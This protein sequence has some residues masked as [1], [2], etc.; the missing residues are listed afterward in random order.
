MGAGADPDMRIAHGW[1]TIGLLLLLSGV[2]RAAPPVEYPIG[3][4][5]LSL[6]VPGPGDT[7]HLPHRLISPRS[8]RVW[9]GERSYRLE[10][11]YALAP[12]EGDLLWLAA[13]P[14]ADS[15]LQ[16]E[17]R[18][19]P[20][21]LRG[22]WGDGTLTPHE[23]G[24]VIALPGDVRGSGPRRLP[25]GASLQVGGS[26]TFSLEFGNRQDV[27]LS[28]SLDLSIRGR[29][30][31]QVT[32]RAVLTDRNVPLQP[33]GT[34]ADLADLD[35]V[36][37]EVNSPWAT[38][39][40]GDLTVTEGGF[41]FLSHRREMEGL[42][43]RTGRRDAPR[44][45]G[46]IGRGV[47]RHETVA[48]FGQDGKQGPYP[49]FA[50]ADSLMQQSSWDDALMIAGSE[51]VWLDG[52]RLQR[53][54]DRDYTVDYSTGG[55]YFTVRRPIFARSEIRVDMQVRRG[56]FD[57]GYAWLSAGLGD[58]TRGFSVA[59]LREED[60][61]SSSATI[62]LGEQERQVL[63][64]AGDSSGAALEGGVHAVTPGEGR[65][66]LV[67][68]DTL[69]T[70]IFV[71]DV[72]A[73]G[74]RHGTYE[75]TFTLVGDEEGDYEID[76]VQSAVAGENVYVYVGRKLGM[77]LPGRPL[78]LPES[79]DV[80][81]LRGALDL[82][83]GLRLAG[84]GALSL[85]DQN[86]LSGRDDGDNA[87]GAVEASGRWRAAE[88]FGGRAD[89]IELHGRF[90]E[91]A[92]RFASAEPLEKAFYHREWNA[93]ANQ[94][95]GRGRQG[96]A[97]ITLRPGQ[98]FELLTEFES[99]RGSESFSAERWQGRIRR[100]GRI[101]ALAEG[102][103]GESES[104]ASPGR[105][106]RGSA[107]LGWQDAFEAEIGGDWEDLRRGE[108]G[109]ASGRC[110]QVLQARVSSGRLLPWVRGTLL[111]RTRRDDQI[112]ASRRQ[113]ASRT[114]LTQAEGEVSGERG[115]AHLRYARTLTEAADGRESRSD[116]AD[117]IGSYR[118]A[119]GVFS[120]EWRG[121]LTVEEAAL[122]E[123][124]LFYMGAGGGHYDSLGH[125]VGTGD[126][127]LYYARGD[128]SDL[129]TELE[130]ALRVAGR[131]FAALGEAW[132]RIEGS[133]YAKLQLGTPQ[134]VG[135]LL[136]DL[137]ALLTGAD[138]ARRYDALWRNEVT[139]KAPQGRPTPR[140]RVEQRRQTQRNISGFVRERRQDRI[141][142]DTR[143][144]VRPT[145]QTRLELSSEIER[146]GVRSGPRET[147]YD[148]REERRLALEG[149]WRFRAPLSV[150]VGGEVV[151][152]VFDPSAT[153][154][155][156]YVAELGAL[157]D[158]RR[159]G[160]VE[161]TLIRR[162]IEQNAAAGGAFLLDR[163]GWKLTIN[164]SLRLKGGFTWSLWVRVEEDEGERTITTGRMEARAFF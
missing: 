111:H 162:W 47:G 72:D 149:R 29:L 128:S 134:A 132:Q 121:R 67:E 16:V 66:S 163:P 69:A 43:L 22:H 97:G 59:W 138:P 49:L 110:A 147:S 137:G 86:I 54:E 53:G 34:T 58:S 139:W 101:T 85:H 79:L 87:G 14:A 135:A 17:Y 81:A 102:S 153:T 152:E 27:S 92:A 23:R 45:D 56:V 37:I 32:I 129:E 118:I 76:T 164:G 55:L 1:G 116:L 2:V 114:H 62:P 12:V 154:R 140:L 18:Y 6:P 142:L 98:G 144:Q 133:S 39:N 71:W 36:L 150:K 10:E 50:R 70:A 80:M 4:A 38:L 44:A 46:A 125:Y 35:E 126:Y 51:R 30:A 145:L 26:K 33:T 11:D 88:A 160:R 106:R 3:H 84:E 109:A 123:E 5:R 40:L 120:G 52:V 41:R 77:Y 28:Q 127:D 141:D 151:G 122:L 117:W 99:V 78:P 136:G 104:N 63:A 31:E 143:W 156:H 157:A 60:D 7:L 108:A 48:F 94:M 107:R 21:D 112:T 131:P 155:D 113:E 68:G 42:A 82:G 161:I 148:Q 20:L 13:R 25:P 15:T 93:S 73:T 91:V 103:L 24:A 158:F 130:S 105:E 61:P 96:A 115:L 89:L 100:A 8:L 9:Q 64:A 146:E 65:Y 90:R 57:R 95:N 75:V 159:R 74:L 83:G 19:L 124:R 119:D